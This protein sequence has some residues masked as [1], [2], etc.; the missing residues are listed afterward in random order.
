M[1]SGHTNFVDATRHHD[2]LGCSIVDHDGLG[3]LSVYIG[4]WTAG[5]SKIGHRA[6]VHVFGLRFGTMFSLTHLRSRVTGALGFCFMAFTGGFR[7]GDEGQMGN[8]QF[9]RG[10]F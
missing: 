7:C 2:D 8:S 1:G 10:D 4:K 5:E 9:V 3:S 6:L